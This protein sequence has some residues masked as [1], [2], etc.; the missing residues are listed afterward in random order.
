MLKGSNGGKRVK[1]LIGKECVK[2][3]KLK[4]RSFYHSFLQSEDAL[5]ISYFMFCFGRI[6][7]V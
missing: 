7:E 1:G 5:K 3:G 6:P 4:V 2:I